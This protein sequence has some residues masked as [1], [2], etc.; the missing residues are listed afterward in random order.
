MF[1]IGL[2]IIIYAHGY[3]INFKNFKIIKTGIINLSSDP[4]I[5]D[6]YVDNKLVS[7][8]TPYSDNYLPGYYQV[9]IKKDGFVSWHSRVRVAPE[10]VSSY[11]N[12]VLF[13]NNITPKELTNNKNIEQLSA[14]NDELV[15]N[16]SNSLSFNDFEIWEGN[17][18]VARF[19]EPISKA[20]WYPDNFHIIYQQK[21]QIRIIENLG[22]NDT[23]LVTLSSSDP[24]NLII[25][26]KGTE[27]YYKDSG[28]Y[29]MATIR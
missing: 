10:M 16:D 24:T 29:I 18:L 6:V 15:K 27:I 23:L 17:N 11:K 4:K 1:L 12:V 8:K 7:Q 3:K 21:N 14:P 5:A 28:K 20:I 26:S 22:T 19:S 25:D 13:K 9:E 2:S